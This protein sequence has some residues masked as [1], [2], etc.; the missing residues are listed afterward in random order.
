MKAIVCKAWGLPDTLVV[1]DLPDLTAAGS[2]QVVIEVSKPQ[3]LISRM[4]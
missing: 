2:G 4:S 1:D 3:A